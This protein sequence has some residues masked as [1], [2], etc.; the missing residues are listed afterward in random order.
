MRVIDH[1]QRGQRGFPIRP[2]G[3]HITVELNGATILDADLKDVT[4]FLD[5]KAHPGKDL[6][7][8]F[9]GF[10]GHGDPVMFRRIAI[11]RLE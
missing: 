3:S 2:A 1:V 9:F 10:A 11:K 8:G 4:E 6:K 7:E 5:G